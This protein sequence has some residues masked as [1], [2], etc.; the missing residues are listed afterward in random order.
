M[1]EISNIDRTLKE[2]RKILD[3]RRRLSDETI[4]ELIETLEQIRALRAAF[5]EKWIK[6]AV[7]I[8]EHLK[9][10]AEG[11]DDTDAEAAEGNER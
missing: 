10:L 7:G 3:G 11:I 8:L 5:P 2:L 6:E 4:E 9:E 1:S